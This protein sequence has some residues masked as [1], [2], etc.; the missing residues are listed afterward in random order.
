MLASLASGRH[1]HD[2]RQNVQPGSPR[3]IARSIAVACSAPRRASLIASSCSRCA[4]VWSRRPATRRAMLVRIRPVMSS[5]FSLL[6]GDP[7]P[8]HKRSAL[9]VT[10]G[11]NIRDAGLPPPRSDRLANPTFA[12]RQS[13]VPAGSI[14]PMRRLS[15]GR[16]KAVRRH[17]PMDVRAHSRC[18]PAA[19]ADGPLT[20][21]TWRDA[22]PGDPASA[23][24]CAR[25]FPLRWASWAPR[26]RAVVGS[27]SADTVD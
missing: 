8:Q 6:P 4:A 13:A 12:R 9:L 21:A 24:L 19:D 17:L 18:R 22:V 5:P 20:S 3:E 27:V 14:H 16:L 26:L 7:V 15:R 10:F 11:R 23:R 2:Q 1:Q 25:S